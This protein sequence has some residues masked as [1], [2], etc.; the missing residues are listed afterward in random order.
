M[1]T[2]QLSLLR[3]FL[4]FSFDAA[5]EKKRKEKTPAMTS[6]GTPSSK[7]SAAAALFFPVVCATSWV[8]WGW[9]TGAKFEIST[10]GRFNPL[11]PV[12]TWQQSRNRLGG[13]RL[14]TIRSFNW[15]VN[16]L[17]KKWNKIF[18]KLVKMWKNFWKILFG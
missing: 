2:S 8:G 7:E 5:E 9:F 11:A 17:L 6:A 12:A 13:I 18:K 1:R 15:R 10:D 14:N 3:I 4:I 16:L